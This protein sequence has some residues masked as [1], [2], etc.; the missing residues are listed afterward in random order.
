MQDQAR[1]SNRHGSGNRVYCM[2]ALVLGNAGFPAL[3]YDDPE[4]VGRCFR[5]VEKI[6]GD[7]LRTMPVH[8]LST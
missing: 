1:E 4:P 3:L 2:A 6:T 5:R 8:P 7:G